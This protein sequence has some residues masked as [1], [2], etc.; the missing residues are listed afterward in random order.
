MKR[1]EKI[2][3]QNGEAEEEVE[4]CVKKGWIKKWRK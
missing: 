3:A 1:T 2:S 4:S